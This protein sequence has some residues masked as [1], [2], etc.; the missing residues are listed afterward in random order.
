MAARD[1]FSRSMGKFEP[2]TVN[3][4]VAAITAFQGRPMR[5]ARGRRITN[6]V[7]QRASNRK[8]NRE[9][10]EDL[11]SLNL[12]FYPVK[13]AGQ[14]RHWLF[15]LIPYVVPSQE[16]SFIV[17]PRGAMPEATFIP[18]IQS[19]LRKYGQFA[20]AM[21]LPST[22]HAFLLQQDG[23]RQYMGALARPRTAPDDYYT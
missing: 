5:D 15:G 13:G 23:S 9:L 7:A 10:I 22:P 21:K 4:P 12:S 1:S 2:Q 11:K 18:A 16:E 17:Q 3:R 14:E 8:A 20:A 6:P 19:L